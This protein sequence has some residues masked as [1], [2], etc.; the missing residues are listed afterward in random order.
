MFLWSWKE[1]T[2]LKQ[3]H[4]RGEGE[5]DNGKKAPANLVFTPFIHFTQEFLQNKH[6]KNA[7]YTKQEGPLQFFYWPHLIPPL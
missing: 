7:I 1:E 4:Q 6:F 3:R 2:P 5:E